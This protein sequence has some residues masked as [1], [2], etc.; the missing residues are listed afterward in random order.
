MIREKYIMKTTKVRYFLS[1]IAATVGILIGSGSARA[2]FSSCTIAF[3]DYT[4]LQIL[5]FQQAYGFAASPWYY[6]FCGTMGLWFNV[7]ANGGPPSG[8][9]HLWADDPTVNCVTT[10]ATWPNGVMGRMVGN[11]PCNAV[12]PLTTSRSATPHQA[13][14]QIRVQNLSTTDPWRPT[15]I[16][17]RSGTARVLLQHNDGTWWE[18]TNLTPG[19]W[20]LVPNGHK[21]ISAWVM[22]QNPDPLAAITFDNLVVEGP[23]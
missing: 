9:Y 14:F 13:G 4:G 6:N 17:I 19:T 21:A 7:D 2:S 11:G 20:N 23:L 8:H 10:N 5:P 22:N 12:N 18:Y 3:S 15:Q 16:L 1:V